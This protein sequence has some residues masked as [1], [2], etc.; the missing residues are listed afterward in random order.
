VSQHAC[1][2]EEVGP[3]LVEQ[4][5]HRLAQRGMVGEQQVLVD[6]GDRFRAGL[7]RTPGPGH[8]PAVL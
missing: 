5:E 6:D 2:L 1:L 4:V 3:L 7:A 8:Q